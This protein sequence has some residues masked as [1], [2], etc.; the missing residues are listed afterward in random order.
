M[1]SRKIMSCR[2]INENCTSSLSRK[3]QY[4]LIN[5]TS[6]T[7]SYHIC[8]FGSVILGIC[9]WIMS[10]KAFVCVCLVNI[11]TSQHHLIILSSWSL[12]ISLDCGKW[13][14]VYSARELFMSAETHRTN[15]F[16]LLLLPNNT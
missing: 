3:T 1:R 9:S 7:C 8:V 5:S 13:K 12:R 6:N 11:P 10:E 14:T 15:N 4:K 16:F 2:G